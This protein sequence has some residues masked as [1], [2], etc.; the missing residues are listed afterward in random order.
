MRASDRL[1][2][3]NRGRAASHL[4]SEPEP[5]HH[6]RTTLRSASASWRRGHPQLHNC[7]GVQWRDQLNRRRAWRVSSEAALSSAL[8]LLVN[9]ASARGAMREGCPCCA[10]A[11]LL[12]MPCNPFATPNEEMAVAG[13]RWDSRANLAKLCGPM[14]NLNVCSGLV[15]HMLL[16]PCFF[17]WAITT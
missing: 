1:A 14:T 3:V 5:A 4:H 6:A 9:C 2:G 15:V 17:V 12:D 13:K 16:S 7:G 10:H 11:S 8:G